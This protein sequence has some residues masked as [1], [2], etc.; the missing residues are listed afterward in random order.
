[1]GLFNFN[2]GNPFCVLHRRSLDWKWVS[3]TKRIGGRLYD[4][5]MDDWLTCMFHV[6]QLRQKS[7][8]NGRWRCSMC[9][10]FQPA[11]STPAIFQ[12]T[13]CQ[14]TMTNRSEI[15]ELRQWTTSNRRSRVM[16]PQDHCRNPTVLYGATSR[17]VNL[18]WNPEWRSTHIHKSLAWVPFP[19]KMRMLG[20]RAL[21]C[22]QGSFIRLGN[23]RFRSLYFGPIFLEI[24]YHAASVG[25]SDHR[26][27]Q[28]KSPYGLCRVQWLKRN[29]GAN[30]GYM[31]VTVV[32][33]Y[34]GGGNI[35]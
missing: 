28:N 3:V 23:L 34:S 35:T 16:K 1:M 7:T 21:K 20:Y 29:R 15:I 31:C 26:T 19:P 9:R 8:E 22:F 14:R 11:R 30:S 32:V 12:R 6:N 25:L 10:R 5:S 2:G 18:S 17:K 4:L 13:N 33:T 27:V 24:R